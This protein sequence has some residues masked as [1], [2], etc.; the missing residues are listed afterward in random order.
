MRSTFAISLSFALA[1]LLGASWCALNVMNTALPLHVRANWYV[2]GAVCTATCLVACAVG[3]V[4]G[5]V[6]WLRQR[7]Q[8]SYWE[9]AIARYDRMV[10]GK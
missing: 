8:A 6:L 3:G 4:A 2:L 1:Y 5:F 9:R 7:R 10:I